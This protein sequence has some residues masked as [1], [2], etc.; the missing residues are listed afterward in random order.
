V[1]HESV[2]ESCGRRELRLSGAKLRT[3]DIGSAVALDVADRAGANGSPSAEFDL[4]QALG[5]TLTAQL[6]VTIHEIS[7][8]RRCN[9]VPA[10]AVTI[11]Y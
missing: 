2:D 7:R 1:A 11:L 10:D 6:M 9:S 8:C 3:R 5:V 4:S